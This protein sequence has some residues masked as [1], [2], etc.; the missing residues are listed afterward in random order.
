MKPHAAFIYASV[1][2]CCG[3]KDCEQQWHIEHYWVNDREP[4]E[5]PDY[6]LCDEG[7]NHEPVDSLPTAEE[8]NE[9]WGRYYE[10]V[11]STGEDPIGTFHVATV[12][13][14]TEVWRVRFGN[15]ILGVMVLK[16]RKGRTD[17]PVRLLPKYVREFL[18][19]PADPTK[20]AVVE[21]FRHDSEEE[22]PPRKRFE[23]LGYKFYRW[24]TIEVENT[25]CIEP[26]KVK[27]ELKKRARA[28]LSEF[29]QMNKSNKL[30]LHNPAKEPR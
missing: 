26:E 10:H 24:E 9:A 18:E 17:V 28:A 16:V 4:H 29:R 14:V 27:A 22:L 3:E 5:P 1:P 30:P 19:L 2:Y 21:S 12:K 13:K 25:A 11:A 6:T 15:S 23:A 20:N 8:E 7:G